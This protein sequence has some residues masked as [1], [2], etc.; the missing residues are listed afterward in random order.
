MASTRRSRKPL[1]DHTV[2]LNSETVELFTVETDLKHGLWRDLDLEAEARIAEMRNQHEERLRA[3]KERGRELIDMLPNDIANMKVEDLTEV[4]SQSGISTE[5]F[6][7][8][9]RLE[10]LQQQ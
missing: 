1:A 7:V 2:N 10:Y 5:E 4:L 8:V 6:L 9:K 3:V